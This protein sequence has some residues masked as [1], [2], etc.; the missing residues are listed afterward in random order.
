MD[1]FKVKDLNDRFAANILQE[2]I[3][4]GKVFAENAKGL[5]TA[6]IFV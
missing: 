5:A 6:E 1:R 4:G 2:K 3:Y